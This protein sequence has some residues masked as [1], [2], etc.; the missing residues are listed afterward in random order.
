[1]DE[2]DKFEP[3]EP[4]RYPWDV[5]LAK[6]GKRVVLVE[7]VDYAEG[8]TT[9]MRSGIY[10]AARRKNLR[11]RTLIQHDSQ[12]RVVGIVINPH[13][14]DYDEGNQRGPGRPEAYPYDEWFAWP[15]GEYY[16][17]PSDY[18]GGVGAMKNR[19]MEAA[20]R[21]RVAV[22]VE[23]NQHRAIKIQSCLRCVAAGLRWCDQ[24]SS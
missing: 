24:H 3:W 2:T 1:M 7:G 13:R 20:R 19:I 18:Q 11:V 14:A 15:S 9:G 21:H 12:D 6:Q 17:Q 10:Q 8:K 22:T 16:L 4:T 5:W 23:S